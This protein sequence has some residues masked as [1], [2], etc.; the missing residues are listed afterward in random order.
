MQRDLLT[1]KCGIPRARR[2]RKHQIENRFPELFK[3]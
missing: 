3:T 1:Q 2:F